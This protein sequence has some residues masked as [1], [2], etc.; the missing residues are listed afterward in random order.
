MKREHTMAYK[1]PT[2]KQDILAVLA[3]AFEDADRDFRNAP[4]NLTQYGRGYR[5][6]A[7]DVMYR[8][9]SAITIYEDGDIRAAKLD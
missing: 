6:G 4:D 8:I 9:I 1:S 5:D 2:S 7:F 3:A